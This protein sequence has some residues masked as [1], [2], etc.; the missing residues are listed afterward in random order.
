MTHVS[1]SSP[2]LFKYLQSVVRLIPSCL[3][4]AA[5]F[6]LLEATA[7][8]ITWRMI[9]SRVRFSA[10]GAEDC[11]RGRRRVRSL[12]SSS[13]TELLRTSAE[14][15]QDARVWTMCLNCV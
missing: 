15:V 11:K 1:I 7:S 8:W 13:A 12:D 6:P 10:A 14:E 9:S 2:L 5:R 3:A 4:A